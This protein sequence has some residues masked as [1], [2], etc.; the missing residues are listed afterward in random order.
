VIDHGHILAGGKP[1]EL[2]RD[3]VSNYALE[4]RDVDSRPLLAVPPEITAIERGGAHL[5][6]APAPEALTPLLKA[7]E[8]HRLVVRPSHL[9]DV[10][11]QLVD[12]GEAPAK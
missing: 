9:E 12:F 2:V 1:H 7:Y 11:L 6:F 10:F 5:Y 4:V 3:R 8:G